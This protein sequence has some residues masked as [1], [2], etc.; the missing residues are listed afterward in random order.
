MG[1]VTPDEINAD[2]GQSVE[3]LELIGHWP[4]LVLLHGVSVVGEDEKVI[5]LRAERLEKAVPIAAVHQ[6]ENVLGIAGRPLVEKL[7][8]A[9]IPDPVPADLQDPWGGRSILP[10]FQTGVVKRPFLPFQ[11]GEK[12]TSLLQTLCSLI[13][14]VVIRH[15][16]DFHT[17]FDGGQEEPGVGVE[18]REPRRRRP[19]VEGS[20]EIEKGKVVAS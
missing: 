7:C 18:I 5:L 4:G 1:V 19:S 6:V 16:N 11:M 8:H 17:P 9:E 10:P 12:S 3:K 15:G 20:F 2:L 13:Q 14:D